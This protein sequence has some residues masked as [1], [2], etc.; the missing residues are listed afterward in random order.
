M[1]RT[2][3]KTEDGGWIALDSV[4]STEVVE[5][6][7]NNTII[8]GNLVAITNSGLQFTIHSNVTEDQLAEH[9]RLMDAYALS[10]EEHNAKVKKMRDKISSLEKELSE[11]KILLSK[12]LEFE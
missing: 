2:F 11:L 7:N 1:K 5:H 8:N 10:V 9:K 12:E 4:V 3:I 6:S